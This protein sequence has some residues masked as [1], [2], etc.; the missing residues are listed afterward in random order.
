MSVLNCFK[1]LLARARPARRVK[2]TVRSSSLCQPPCPSPGPPARPSPHFNT[3]SAS[4][5]QA[6]SPLAFFPA[7]VQSRII[8]YLDWL[9]LT[10]LRSSC[11]HF[12]NLPSNGQLLQALLDFEVSL[13]GLREQAL[14]LCNNKQRTIDR[15][16]IITGVFERNGISM[17]MINADPTADRFERLDFRMEPCYGCFQMIWYS[18]FQRRGGYHKAPWESHISTKKMPTRSEM[19]ARRCVSCQLASS[20]AIIRGTKWI[21]EEDYGNFR[22]WRVRCTMCLELDSVRYLLHTSSICGR[23]IHDGL[24]QKCWEKENAEWLAH[25]R[26]LRDCMK[27]LKEYHNWMN[28]IDRDASDDDDDDAAVAPELPPAFEACRWA[29]EP[30]NDH[31]VRQR[32]IVP[33]RISGSSIHEPVA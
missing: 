8:D 2:Q 9:S 10:R 27:G 19:E 33:V 22:T 32:K 31:D 3:S 1:S 12:R 25:K 21:R 5:S 28:A 18:E 13:W 15:A 24:C 29:W 26:D 16:K 23:Q 14:A 11:R 7:E 4:S 30:F 17:A 6:S 20:E